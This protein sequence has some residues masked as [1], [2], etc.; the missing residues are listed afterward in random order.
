MLDFFR[1]NCLFQTDQLYC[2][3]EIIRFIRDCASE[4]A[5]WWEYSASY[6]LHSSVQLYKQVNKPPVKITYTYMERKCALHL[7]FIPQRCHSFC[8][9]NGFRQLGWNSSNAAFVYVTETHWGICCKLVNTG[10]W[11]TGCHYLKSAPFFLF[12][13]KGYDRSQRGVKQPSLSFGK[14][15]KN[16]FDVAAEWEQ[17]LKSTIDISP[18]AGFLKAQSDCCC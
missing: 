10:V 17:K 6:S 12:S 5:K 7:I 11:F 18:L 1:R 4:K 2:K 9:F 16:T 3:K 15:Q 8:S 13:F 14:I